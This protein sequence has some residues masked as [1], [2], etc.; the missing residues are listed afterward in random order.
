MLPEARDSW[1]AQARAV[2]AIALELSIKLDAMKDF[3]TANGLTA[4]IVD[5][6]TGE[7]PTLIGTNM[8]LAD[9]MA[10]VQLSTDASLFLEDPIVPDGM[11]R[12]LF[13]RKI[14]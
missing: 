12:R 4:L 13:F 7:S 8:A 5:S 6:T 2:N 3:A 9:V 1:V 14:V 11:A 10:F